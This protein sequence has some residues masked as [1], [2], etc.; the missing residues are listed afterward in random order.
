MAM[1]PGDRSYRNTTIRI[2]DLAV[3]EDTL[4]DLT[5]EN[6]VIEGPAVIAFVNDCSMINTTIA[7]DPDSV[8]WVL[9][10]EREYIV[11]AIG[12]VRCTIAGCRLQRIGIAVHAQEAEEY[13]RAFSG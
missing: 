4:T 9:P 3:T 5:F 1:H 7:G 10:P 8:L 2:A 12:L 11:G 6:C 13:R